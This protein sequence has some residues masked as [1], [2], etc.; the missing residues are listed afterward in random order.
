M[1]DGP[2][3]RQSVERLPD[4]RSTLLTDELNKILDMLTSA[5]PEGA[6]ISFDFDGKLHVHVDVH[7][8][9]DILKVEGALPILGGG[10]FHAISRGETPHRPFHHRL[11]AIVDR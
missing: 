4:Q 6:I 8:F 1:S 9:E 11:S 2:V 7:S 10:M 5:C 3:Q